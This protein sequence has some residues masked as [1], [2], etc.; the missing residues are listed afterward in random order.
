MA[1][2]FIAKGYK[3]VSGGTDNHVM[4]D[5]FENQIP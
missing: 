5:R 3:V 1:D 2:A 4:P